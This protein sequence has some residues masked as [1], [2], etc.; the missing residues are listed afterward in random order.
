MI[1]KGY[2]DTSLLA[3]YY[4]PEPLSDKAEKILQSVKC[5]VISLLTEVELLSVV[6]KKIRKKEISRK[7]ADQIFLTYNDHLNEGYYHKVTIT[8]SHFLQAKNLIASFTHTLHSLDSIH[9]AIAISE[10]IPLIT[11]DK[12]L[13]KVAKKVKFESL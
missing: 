8:S 10:K 7:L 13:E 1:E 2:I 9:L 11:L 3:A 4:Y 6:S 5:P 12:K